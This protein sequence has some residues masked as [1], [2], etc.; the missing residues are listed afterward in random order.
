MVK[1]KTK[2]HALKM[3]ITPTTLS[4]KKLNHIIEF[5]FLNVKSIADR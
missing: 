2:T 4:T 1:S 5:Q 3:Y